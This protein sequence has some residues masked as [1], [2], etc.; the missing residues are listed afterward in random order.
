MHSGTLAPSAHVIVVGNTK[1]GSG[2]STVSLHLAI[3]LLRDGHRVATIDADTRQRTLSRSIEYRRSWMQQA[4]LALDLPWHVGL[5]A[6]DG[7]ARGRAEDATQRALAGTL[8]GLSARFDFVVI[9]TPGSDSHLTRL[10]HQAADTLVTP[11]NDS[12][13]D[14]DVIGEVDAGRDV[15]R[16]GPYAGVVAEARA[17]RRAESG[18][19]VDWV[20]LRNRLGTL[21]SRNNRAVALGLDRLAS[22]FGFRVADGISERVIFRELF[23][24]GLTALDRLDAR[25][26]GRQPTMSH[27]AARREI[28]ELLAALRLPVDDRGRKR[29]E[30]RR[31]WS[32]AAARP[33]HELEL[34][35]A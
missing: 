3:A 10:V 4:G 11:I 20:V 29:K 28:R 26:L 24:R 17:R 9:D 32:E 2:K 14:F 18:V 8:A 16:E 21:D 31:A 34:P 19:I 5:P 25:T 15:T 22:A 7:E 30:I 13:L 23:P 1:G 35:L 12:F 33:L 27:L 6:I